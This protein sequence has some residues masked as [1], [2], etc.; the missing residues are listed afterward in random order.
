[1]KTKIYLSKEQWV[2]LLGMG[3]P[4]IYDDINDVL[5]WW[6]FKQEYQGKKGYNYVKLLSK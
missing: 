3:D 2:A 6:R 1:M 5:R 4:W